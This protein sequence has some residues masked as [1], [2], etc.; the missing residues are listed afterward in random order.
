M[1]INL[2][3]IDL[4]SKW[5]WSKESTSNVRSRVARFFQYVSA[6][7]YMTITCQPRNPGK[8]GEHLPIFKGFSDVGI[9][10][11]G[12]IKKEDDYTIETIAYYR[13]I[14]PDCQLVLSTWVDE[15]TDD[16]IGK[17]EEYKCAVIQNNGLPAEDKGKGEK[18]GHLNNQLFSSIEGLYYLKECDVQ[19]ALKMR[20]DVR[21][22][23]IDFLQYMI[24]LVKVYEIGDRSLYN[25]NKR[26][27]N[28]SF[29]NTLYYFPFHMSD[30]VWFGDIDDMIKLYSIHS[31]TDE[32][33]KFIR[34]K[35]SIP[36]YI[37][38]HAKKVQIA[39]NKIGNVDT[40]NI[41]EW[42][43]NLEI[44]EKFMILYHE[45]IYIMYNFYLRIYKQDISGNILDRYH[46][47][48]KNVIIAV[49]EDD[50]HVSFTKYGA[51]F[52]RPNVSLD[53]V[54][55]YSHSMWLNDIIESFENE[56]RHL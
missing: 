19:Y 14:Y 2:K 24:N 16:E 9:V 45:E 38:Q 48:L 42:F 50:M 20:T 46:D 47:F 56:G 55:R 8:Q 11:Q 34:E 21:I 37:S 31:R 51:S 40:E 54:K 26:L 41:G 10:L 53:L 29:S 7:K 36:G 12:P 5:E 6:K 44:E 3:I 25:V 23:R 1:N 17:L 52:Y 15:L 4:L 43:E 35:V 32:E 33:L 49:D 13:K 27:L 18:I 22:N 28:V 30:F 39:I